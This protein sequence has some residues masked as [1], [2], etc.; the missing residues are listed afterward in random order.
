MIDKRYDIII[1]GAGPSGATAALFASQ[2]GIKTLILD[3]EKF[4]RDKICG[5]A[6]SGK[7]VGILKELGLMEK[8]QQLPGA[9]IQRIVFSSP[10]HT[11]FQINLRES[12]LKDTPKGFVIRRKIFDHFLVEEVKKTNSQ[13]VEG[14]TVTDIIQSGNS[15]CGVVGIDQN[16][17]RHEIQCN[18]VLA[19]DGYNSTISRKLGI[20]HHD[21]RHWVVALRCYYKNVAGLSDQIEL[22]YLDDVIPGYFW[23]FPV[24]EGYANIGIGMLHH[25]IKKGHIDLSAALEKAI[26]HPVFTNRF[27]HATPIEKPIGWNLPV[28]SKRRKNNGNGFLLLGDAAGLIDPFTG[29]GIGNAMYSAKFAIDTIKQALEIN[30]YDTN[31][32]SAYD[33]NLWRMIGDELR[34]STKLQKIGKYRFL[35]NFVIRKASRNP[36]ISHLIAGMLANEVPR[37][38]LAN[39]LFYLRLLLN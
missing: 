15:V 28:G 20:Y 23:I 9:F 11:S 7:S 18:V 8:V 34:V 16:G 21:P 38:K 33:R 35:L 37:D 2:H 10:D 12:N 24:E 4:P 3:K 39:P 26:N 5:D 27:A 29:E 36:Q 6:L 17:N 31:T 30:A 32:L 1:V 25:Y 22:H 19:A 13:L 14:F